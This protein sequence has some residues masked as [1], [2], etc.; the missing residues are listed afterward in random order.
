M[1]QSCFWKLDGVEGKLKRATYKLY[2]NT[3]KNGKPSTRVRGG[4]ITIVKDS[5]YN[6]NAVTKWMADSDSPK[7]GE[8]FIYI[9]E[10]KEK[11]LKTISWKNGYVIEQTESFIDE[12]GVTNTEEIFTI[13][14]EFLTVDDAEYDFY[15][16]ETNA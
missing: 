4:T 7:D 12:E 8:I 9:D 11:K 16:P 14:A 3:E 1:A 13:S 15:W 6:Q 10:K 5:I 2:R